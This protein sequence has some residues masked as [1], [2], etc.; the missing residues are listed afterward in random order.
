MT[1]DLVKIQTADME[2]LHQ[3]TEQVMGCPEF[4]VSSIIEGHKKPGGL[5]SARGNQIHEVGAKIAAWCAQ[6]G[7]AM[8][9]EAFDRFSKG[10]G[11]TATKILMGMRDSYEVDFAHMLDT[12]VRMSLDEFMQ[13]TETYAAIEGIAGDSGLRP[14]FQGTLDVIYAYPDDAKLYIDDLKSHP[15]PF[16]PS[17]TL[18]GKMYSVFGFQ[19][20]PWVETVRFRLIFVRYKK[21]TR[22]VT[23]TREDLPG[24]IEEIK[25]ARERQRMLHVNYAAGKTAEAIPGAH[26]QYCPLLTNLKCPIADYNENIQYTDEQWLKFDLWYSAFSRANKKRMK[27]RVQATGKPIVLKDYNGKA[28]VYG[29]TESESLVFPLFLKTEKSIATKCMQCGSRFDHV[30]E[31]GKCPS[32][33]GGLVQPIMPIVEHLES[34]A[35]GTPGDTAFMGNVMISSTSLTKYTSAKKRAFLDQACSD[36]A[37]HVTKAPLRVSKPLDAVPDADPDDDEESWE[38]SDDF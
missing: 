11:P 34:Y 20:F 14:A 26:C 3:S 10:A 23:Y 30:P 18:Q 28:Y 37:D 29:P 9:L 22:E 15:R 36:T 7:V 27:D 1:T 8:D 5:E 17:E 12:E 21:M 4:Y 6:K 2:P 19:H 25:A 13:P 35:H 32:C 24:L 31:D 16:E 33:P 38:D